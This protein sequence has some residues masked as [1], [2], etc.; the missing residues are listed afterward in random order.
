MRPRG[1]GVGIRTSPCGG[2]ARVIHFSAGRKGPRCRRSRGPIWVTPPP[3]RLVWAT[4]E[5]QAGEPTLGGQGFTLRI[6]AGHVQNR[7]KPLE[8][9]C[10][11]SMVGE[12]ISFAKIHC[13]PE[14]ILSSEGNLTFWWVSRSPCRLVWRQRDSL[15]G[16]G[17]WCPA[18]VPWV[19]VP[20][21]ATEGKAPQK[22]LVPGTT[23]AAQRGAFQGMAD[24]RLSS[25]KLEAGVRPISPPLCWEGEVR[26]PHQSFPYVI[27][28]ESWWM[29]WR[30]I[31][32]EEFFSPDGSYGGLKCVVRG[33][34]CPTLI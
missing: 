32:S 9:V 11:P 29:C 17:G 8:G 34:A 7:Q 28:R 16:A 10:K 31:S 14:N 18:R 22:C 25:A 12:V 21:T 1:T 20:H 4:I 33:L 19:D 6:S 2:P 23:R 5:G 3:G 26:P 15:K 13:T 24:R 27:V 30:W